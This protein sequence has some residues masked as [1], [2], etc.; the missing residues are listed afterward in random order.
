MLL[1][2]TLKVAAG[3]CL[4]ATVAVAQQLPQMVNIESM[5]T[6]KN[7]VQEAISNDAVKN[8][9][10]WIKARIQNVPKVNA[11]KRNIVFDPSLKV[12]GIKQAQ[13]KTMT[14]ANEFG[15]YYNIPSGIY[16][17]KPGVYYYNEEY[18]TYGILAPVMEE[19][20]YTNASTWAD[21]FDWYIN[22]TI[23]NNEDSLKTVYVPLGTTWWT[24]MPELTAYASTG[25]DSI[26]QYG[27]GVD[28]FAE[29]Y[30]E[31]EGQAVTVGNGFI[32][33]M[34]AYT[35]TWMNAVPMVGSAGTWADMMFGS[36]NEMKP[37]YIELFDKP[38][39]SIAFDYA[40]LTVA[41][42]EG[43]DLTAKDFGLSV[44][45]VE[46]GN[47]KEIATATATPQYQGSITTPYYDNAFDS[48]SLIIPLDET[49]VLDQEFALVLEGPQDGETPW[50]FLC[51]WTRD[52]DG[53]ATAGFIPSEGDYKGQI[54][55]YGIQPEGYTAPIA[56]PTS[57]DVALGAYTPF[58][59]FFDPES[60]YSIN[61]LN[62]DTVAIG[63]GELIADLQLLNW[64]VWNFGLTDTSMK[65]TSD[66]DWLTASVTKTPT[67]EDISYV[68]RINATACPSG[69][70]FGTLTFTDS[71]GY[72][73][74]LTLYQQFDPEGI[75]GIIA[76]KSQSGIDFDAPIYDLTGRRVSNPTK[77]IYL[78]NG[79]K[80]VIH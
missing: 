1:N 25:Q 66:S 41:A 68:Y 38:L 65:V 24:P 50:A 15:A 23:L 30:V 56:F 40:M 13:P 6:S 61:M 5:K 79:K 51:D 69:E 36:N 74:T 22:G 21:N 45:I 73:S 64:V 39:G 4:F 70:R 48:W 75:E 44:L 72:S 52:V 53:R 58:N 42:P 76:D 78:Q 27:W 63:G 62:N 3:L 49:I 14:R 11:P 71:K 47:W 67:N 16:N 33:N 35:I 43:T 26:Y 12:T 55:F 77:G 59:I 10:E 29:G 60:G 17:L 57:I 7:L 32:Q 31:R 54:M 46:D 20:V 8:N 28:P 37:M 19:V 2:K 9:F 80:M 18:C 34:D